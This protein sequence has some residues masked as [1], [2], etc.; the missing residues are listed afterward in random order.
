MTDIRFVEFQS[1]LDIIQNIR[2]HVFTLEQ[3]VDQAIDFDGQDENAILVIACEGEIPVGTGRMLKD[4]HIG[5]IAV[6]AEQ[7]KKGI[8][9][10]IV[11]ALVNRAK[12]EGF[13]R[14]HLGA[15]VNAVPFYEKLGFHRQGE[16]YWEADILH[17]PM[18]KTF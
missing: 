1:C 5:R 16:D 8:G 14:V 10:D 13:S 4:G 3:G 12:Q 17:T 15:Q 9:T 18:S 7:R 6:L 11:M 2:Y